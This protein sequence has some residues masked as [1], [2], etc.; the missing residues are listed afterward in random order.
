MDIQKNSL[1]NGLAYAL[2]TA[3]AIVGEVQD[4]HL[5]AYI[6]RP[7]MLLILSS[8]FFFNSRRVGDRFTLLIQAGLLFSMAGDAF[9]MFQHLDQFNFLVGLGAYLIG[10][11]CYIMAFTYN[12]TEVGGGEGPLVPLAISVLVVAFLFLFGARMVPYVEDGVSMPLL[13]FGSANAALSI[14]AAFRFGRTFVRS[15]LMVTLGTFFFIGSNSLLATNRFMVPLDHSDW[16]I[17]LTYAIAQYLVV[18]GSL[19]HVLDP[20]EIRRKAAL[21][22]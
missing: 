22:T 11:L 12:I 10:L 19:V 16:S 20:E 4:L 1:V 21:V 14:T 8:W 17:L 3:G 9:L 5:L 18:A 7:L 6:C 2:A 15:F 13:I